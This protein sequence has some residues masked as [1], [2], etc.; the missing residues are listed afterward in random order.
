[1][2][3]PTYLVKADNLAIRLLDLAELHEEVPESGL[4]NDRVRGEDSHAVELWG[5]VGLGGQV[6]P[7]NLIFVETP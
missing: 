5:G 3:V 4:G 7:D 2:C 6:T 1:M